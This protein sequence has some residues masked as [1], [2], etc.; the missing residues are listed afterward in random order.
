MICY[1]LKYSIIIIN[2]HFLLC[3]LLLYRSILTFSLS[4]EQWKL[5]NETY[6]EYIQQRRL[7]MLIISIYGNKKIVTVVLHMIWNHVY[8]WFPCVTSQCCREAGFKMISDSIPAYRFFKK[9]SLIFFC[10]PFYFPFTSKFLKLRLFQ[11][12][13]I[14]A[15]RQSGHH[16]NLHSVIWFADD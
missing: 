7:K 15:G 11:Y 2:L 3:Y 1:L 4:Q 14:T 9:F 5:L 8:I 6:W 13:T 12:W 16:G 10:L